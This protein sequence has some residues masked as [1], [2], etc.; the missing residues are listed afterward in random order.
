MNLLPKKILRQNSIIPTRN[1]FYRK[2]KKINNIVK[3]LAS[4]LHSETKNNNLYHKIIILN[5][6]IKIPFYLKII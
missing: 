4:S 3:L 5:F 1:F 6:I 2:M